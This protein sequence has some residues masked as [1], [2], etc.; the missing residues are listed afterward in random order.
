M[1]ASDPAPQALSS[2]AIGFL[3]KPLE[4][5][6]LDAAFERIETFLERKMKELLV[7]EDDDTLCGAILKLIGNGD[8][9]GVGTGSGDEALDMLRTH[10]YDCII[11]DLNLSDMSGFELLETADRDERITL[12]PVIV[13]TGRELTRE[14]GARLA[15]YSD[16]II[17]KG[18][19]S[20]E[21]L[22]DEASLFLH[23]MVEK[24]PEKKRQMITSLHDSDRMFKNKTVLIVDDDMRNL[25]ALSGALSSKGLTPLKAQDGQK[26]MDMLKKHPEIDLVLMDIMMPVMDGYETM[27]AIRAE[28]KWDKLPI[29][30]LTAKARKDDRR[31]CIEAGANDYLAKPVDMDRLLSMMRVWMYR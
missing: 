29:I 27:K 1:S 8:V 31:K 6:E 4:K 16:S 25:F 2:G 23:R 13:Y 28:I 18:V 19:R 10:K 22:F 7:I 5:Q 17:V 24:M 15:T 9:H 14:E 20:R 26:A 3:R 11:L 12:P 21:R 30:A